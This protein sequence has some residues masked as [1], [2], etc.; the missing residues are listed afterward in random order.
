MSQAVLKF[1]TSNFVESDEQLT[2]IPP[3]VVLSSPSLFVI[4]DS[5]QLTL[6]FLDNQ[7]NDAGYHPSLLTLGFPATRGN[8]IMIVR[9]LNDVLR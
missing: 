4:L 5:L 6:V 2:S 1:I 9:I 7:Y 3:A 8:N